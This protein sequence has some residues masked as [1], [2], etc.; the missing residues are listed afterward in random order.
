[1]DRLMGSESLMTYG[2]LVRM[3]QDREK[4]MRDCARTEFLLTRNRENLPSWY[5]RAMV[6]IG[7]ELVVCGTWLKAHSSAQ[8]AYRVH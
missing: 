8:H 4:E 5:A 2:T 3:A 7:D 6:S 1:M